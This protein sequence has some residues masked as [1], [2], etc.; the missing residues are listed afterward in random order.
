MRIVNKIFDKN[1]KE[2]S[3]FSNLNDYLTYNPPKAKW[4]FNRIKTNISN[5]LTN[6]PGE[7]GFKNYLATEFDNIIRATPTQLEY[8]INEINRDYPN[9]LFNQVSRKQTTFGHAIENAFEYEVF[10]KTSKARWLA[11]SLNIKS[12]LYCN[13]QFTLCITKESS[14]GLLFQFDHF[15]SKSKYPYLSLSM[16]NL[17]PSCSNCNIAKSKIDF[18]LS[19]AVH[20]YHEDINVLMNFSVSNPDILDYLLNFNKS[21]K[22]SILLKYTSLKAKKHIDTFSLEKIYNQ[23]TDFVEE[24]FLKTYYYNPSKIKELEE[25]FKGI[26]DGSVSV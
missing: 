9:L 17:I 3:L 5:L 11:N 4:K 1:R 21:K 7:I 19:N 6:T 12:C 14:T 23:H 2:I 26:I 10:R 15:F 16:C 20:P 22:T 8:Y 25:V 13:A 24:I 18:D